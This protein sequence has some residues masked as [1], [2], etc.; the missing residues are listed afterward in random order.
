MASRRINDFLFTG[1]LDTAKDGSL[2][3]IC[4]HAVIL[5]QAYLPTFFPTMKLK[6]CLIDHNT[7]PVKQD[8]QSWID[9][10]VPVIRNYERLLVMCND[11]SH[12]SCTVAAVIIAASENRPF[13]RVVAELS[14]YFRSP[15]Q[16]AHTWWPYSHW[17]DNIAKNWG[18][19]IIPKQEAKP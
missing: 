1:G 6:T 15:T 5:L 4:P 2:R 14:T 10:G 18:Q 3:T 8:I 13:T 11:G 17:Y 12:R 7:S 16:G 19:L 9:F